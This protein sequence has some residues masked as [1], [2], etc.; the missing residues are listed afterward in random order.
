MPKRKVVINM[1]PEIKIGK[2]TVINVPDETGMYETPK[3][4]PL[5][6]NTDLIGAENSKQ[7]II[8]VSDAVGGTRVLGLTHEGIGR[9]DDP[10]RGDGRSPL[11]EIRLHDRPIRAGYTRRSWHNSRSLGSPSGGYWEKYKEIH[12]NPRWVRGHGQR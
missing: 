1:S 9:S 10:I 3:G 5:Y 4:K 2:R 12:M 6:V 7:R 8:I 11:V